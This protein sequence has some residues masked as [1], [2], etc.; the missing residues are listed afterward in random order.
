MESQ[1][2]EKAEE[3]AT[4]HSLVFGLWTRILLSEEVPRVKCGGCS[5]V[6]VRCQLVLNGGLY[7]S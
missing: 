2:N 1:E 6:G 7:L 3:R 5:V 4:R